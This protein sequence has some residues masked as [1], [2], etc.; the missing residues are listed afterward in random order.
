M[1]A[2]LAI[3]A[4]LG[5]ITTLRHKT[6]HNQY[7]S[8][9]SVRLFVIIPMLLLAIAHVA[10]N[11]FDPRGLYEKGGPVTDWLLGAVCFPLYHLTLV[12]VLFHWYAAGCC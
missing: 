5:L 12:S 3:V 1:W 6:V 8:G 11:A 4:I 2:I 10:F 9:K 7:G